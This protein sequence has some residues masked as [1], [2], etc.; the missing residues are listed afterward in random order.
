VRAGG[1]VTTG[2]PGPGAAFVERISD[3][4]P[5]CTTAVSPSAVYAWSP[6][7]PVS[8]SVV[9]PGGCPWKVS[10]QPSWVRIPSGTSG[11]GSGLVSVIAAPNPTASSETATFSIGGEPVSVTA[12]GASC[13]YSLMPA[14][15]TVGH[16]GG[17]AQFTVNTGTGCPWNVTEA[18][19]AGTLQSAAS[20]FGTA[21]VT[22]DVAANPS[23][24]ATRQFGL[25]IAGLAASVSQGGNCTYQLSFDGPLDGPIIGPDS[26]SSGVRIATGNACTWQLLSDSAWA[27]AS[28]TFA[29]AGKGNGLAT[30]NVT[31]NPLGPTRTA[32]LVVG[33]QA[34]QLTQ[35]SAIGTW[36]LTTSVNPVNAGTVTTNPAPPS[37]SFYNDWTTVCLQPIANPGWIFTGW[38]GDRV[39]FS[40]CIGMEANHAVTAN[41]VQAPSPLALQFVPI[42]PCRVADTRNANGSFGGPSLAAASTRSL[43]IPNS[44]CQ[45]PFTAEAYSLNVAV[46]PAKTLANLTVWPS[47]STEPQ[48]TTLNSLDGRIK[49]GAAIVPAGLAGAVSFN[50]T[51][52]TD[53][54]VDINGYFIPNAGASYLAFYPL[55]PCRVADTRNAR[56]PLGGPS[57]EAAQTRTFPIQSSTCGVPASASAYSLNFS[58]VPAGPLGYLT[59]WPTGQIQPT[60]ATLNAVTGTITANAAIVP[61]GNNGSIDVYATNKTDVVIDIN[62]YFAFPG[63]PGGLW[64]YTLTPCRLLDTRNGGGAFSGTLRIDVGESCGVPAA[65]R[66][67]VL[68]ATVLPAVSL[69]YLT[70]WPDGLAQ[71]VVATLNAVDGAVTSNMAIVPEN[72]G[73][74]DA[75]VASSTN[76]ILDISG[77]FAP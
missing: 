63:A 7:V 4:S 66:A 37:G 34:L 36:K 39:D 6:L 26:T 27:T 41:F 55:P 11:S 61:A 16:G 29:A 49:S 23:T 47:G 53:L 46:V 19:V 14:I 40:N 74:I 72:N 76:L 12:P 50:A 60:V 10:G 18:K 43:V 42:T 68:N 59:A 75:F 67:L 57:Q 15:A 56:G 3:A 35:L 71:P 13:T 58:A 28:L 5:P 51:D 52:Q 62:G 45:I 9:A 24:V 33:D 69:G 32:H 25:Q 20:G 44:A 22:F 21:K 31:P 48:V 1:A 8:F 73:F 54:I 65:A 38:S 17:T 70:M 30:L 64:L 2:V 77:Y